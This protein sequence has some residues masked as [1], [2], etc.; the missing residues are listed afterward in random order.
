M[1]QGLTFPILVLNSSLAVR[2]FNGAAEKLF[3]LISTDVGRPI[4]NINANIEIQDL[5]KKSEMVI[6]TLNSFQKD[7]RDR[8]GHWYSL[9]IRPYKTRDLKIDGVIITLADIHD[10]KQSKG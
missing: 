7:I 4:S 3:N 5:E 6:E 9:Q 2:R 1:L 10:S 8:W